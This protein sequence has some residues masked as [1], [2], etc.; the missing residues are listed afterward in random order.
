MYLRNPVRPTDFEILNFSV[1]KELIACLCAYTQN[2]AHFFDVQNVGII[3]EHYPVCVTLGNKNNA[4]HIYPL[5]LFILLVRRLW[6]FLSE[7][8]S[9]QLHGTFTPAHLRQTYSMRATLSSPHKIYDFA[10]TPTHA[11]AMTIG[12]YHY[13]FCTSSPTR[14]PALFHV[15]ALSLGC[16]KTASWR[17]GQTA[18]CKRNVSDLPYDA[19]PLSCGH[20]CQAA[21]SVR[22]CAKGESAKFHSD[23][24]F[25]NC[26]DEFCFQPFV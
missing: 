13:T 16:S 19:P 9:A 10:G 24:K 1:F 18:R 2:A 3:F 26:I 12:A 6:T 25:Q 11:Q 8:F 14:L 23:L 22:F 21:L 7:S 15:A 17:V 20:I 5:S 4:V